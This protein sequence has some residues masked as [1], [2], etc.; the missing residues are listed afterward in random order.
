MYRFLKLAM[1]SV[2]GVFQGELLQGR[3]VA[4]DAVQPRSA[5]RREVKLDPLSGGILQ[6]F[7]PVMKSGVVQDD[8]QYLRARILS[9]EPLEER[10][11]GPAVL[12]FDEPADQRVPLQVVNAVHVADPAFAAVGG[13]VPLNVPGAGVVLPVAWQQVERPEFVDAEAA[14]IDGAPA[15]VEPADTPV[16]QREVRVGRFLPGLGMPPA[17]LALVEDLPQAFDGDRRDDL[18]LDQ[19]LAELE[20]RPDGHADQ[21]LRR[22]E[23]DLRDLLGDVAHELGRPGAV[24]VVRPPDDG[25][26]AALIEAVDDLSHPLSSEAD[27]LG[28][29]PVTDFAPGQKDDSGVAAVDSVGQLP[30]H[31]VQHPAFPRPQRPNRDPIHD[32]SPQQKPAASTAVVENLFIQ[33]SFVARPLRRKYLRAKLAAW[34]RH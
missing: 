14:A 34:K 12:A 5:G 16:L 1:T 25:V 23:R 21:H 31:L 27:A 29:L 17:N 22:R 28:D 11:E 6:Y 8:V 7:G 30:F 9:A 13:S 18:L 2:V 4:F 32:G 3:K 20:Q 19:V 24:A 26:D 15:P 10:E 33:K